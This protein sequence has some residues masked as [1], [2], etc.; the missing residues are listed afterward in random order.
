M[1]LPVDTALAPRSVFVDHPNLELMK[2]SRESVVGFLVT[3]LIVAA[4]IVF[5]AI[6]WT[7]GFLGDWLTQSEKAQVILNRIAGTIFV[8]LALKLAVPVSYQ[9]TIF[10]I[11]GNCLP[12]PLQSPITA[13]MCG[14]IDVDD[15][16][17]CMFNDDEHIQKFEACG[18]D[19]EEVAGDNR[20][21]VISHER[22]PALVGSATIRTI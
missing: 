22:S 18:D 17:C 13:R 16:T 5:G 19:S 15:S 1:T 11:A 14:D 21:S 7:V 12:K 6:A 20:F 3:R 8:G 10:V 4:L 2:P 9:E